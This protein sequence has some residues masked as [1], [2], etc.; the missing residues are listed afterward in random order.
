MNQV[1]DQW[2]ND[3]MDIIDAE[4]GVIPAPVPAIPELDFD[5]EFLVPDI[6][7]EAVAATIDGLIAR[8]MPRMNGIP[9]GDP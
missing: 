3:I 9:D 4:G 6:T 7:V 5:D 2:L 8:Y 1:G